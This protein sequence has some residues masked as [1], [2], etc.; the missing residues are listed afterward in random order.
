ML[1]QLEAAKHVGGRAGG[2]D[3][4][5]RHRTAW[6]RVR[7]DSRVGLPCALAAAVILLA[8]GADCVRPPRS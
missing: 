5:S 7:R 3:Q 2:R 1:A 4:D 6:L 8:V